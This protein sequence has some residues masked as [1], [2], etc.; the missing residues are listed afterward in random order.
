VA[1]KRQAAKAKPRPSRSRARVAPAKRSAA[2]AALV[3][4]ANPYGPQ[5]RGAKRAIGRR[6][7]KAE[8]YTARA[9]DPTQYVEAAEQNLEKLQRT[10][11]RCTWVYIGV[12]R[13]A[14]AF[15]QIPF[16]IIR[17]KQKGKPGAVLDS[18]AGGLRDLLLHPNPYTSRFDFF[19]QIAVSLKLTG[20][21]FIEKAERDGFKRPTSL[22][23][24]NPTRMTIVAGNAST[25]VKE[26][27]YQLSDRTVTFTADEIIHIR[28]AHPA[29][30]YWGLSPIT[31]ASAPIGTD[32]SS[33]EWN[34]NFMQ[35]GAWPAGS[36]STEHDIDDKTMRRLRAEIKRMVSG[37]KDKAGQVIIL[38]G[39]LKYDKIALSPKDLD[40]LEARRMSRDEILALLGVPLAVAGLSGGEKTT[41]QSAG[42]AQQVVNFYY[43]T[44]FPLLE[45][46]LGSLNREL[47]GLF[48]GELEL[49]PNTRAIPALKEDVQKELVRSQAARTL[50]ASGWSLEMVLAELYPHVQPPAWARVMWTN[51]AMVPIKDDTNPFAKVAGAAVPADPN[52]NVAT[53]PNNPAE[54]DPAGA[55]PG[56]APMKGPTKGI[57]DEVDAEILAALDRLQARYADT[58][59]GTVE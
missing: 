41:N 51:Q 59:S 25:K 42:I 49:V 29:N 37:G 40:W 6:T 14:S 30:D 54:G 36:V 46:V 27:R 57:A 55:D 58:R 56:G 2:S 4:I 43:F 19:E 34:R 33:V 13:I 38:S 9:F 45:K 24:L 39:G 12:N 7:A 18:P 11:G 22:Y 31:V 47:V 48:P 32:L 21:C 15:A 1:A 16:Q 8:A 17:S 53:D 10:Y 20:N 44:I 28:E 5:P 3:E 50:F 52:G 23:V 35:N 26:Y